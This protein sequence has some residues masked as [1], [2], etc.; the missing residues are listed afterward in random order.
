M[1]QIFLLVLFTCQLIIPQKLF[2]QTIN[3]IHYNL[4][5]VPDLSNRL[6]RNTGLPDVDIV[7]A[8]LKNIYPKIANYRRAM[9]QKDQYRV[10]LSSK[11]L[12]TIYHADFSRMYICLNAFAD[13]RK[14]IEYLKNRSKEANLSGATA[15]FMTEFTR[16]ETEA[17]KKTDGADL[18]SFFYSGVDA[19]LSSQYRNIIVLFTDGYIEAGISGARGCEEKQ[20]RYL[21]QQL[22]KQFRK[23]YQKRGDKN[24]SLEMFFARNRYGIIPV[25]N[26][27]LKSFD[28][29]LMQ[30]DDRSLSPTGNATVFPTDYDIMQLFWSDWMKKSGVQHFEMHPIARDT[31][32]AEQIILSFMGVK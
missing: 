29:L 12:G 26:P 2:A 17:R 25:D 21:S 4:V 1:K 13:Q 32:E 7:R 10:V 20:C 18:W 15:M 22:I 14:R 19:N 31:H 5:I 11:R 16:I 28:V 3:T 23:A 24:E 6:S 30:A 27:Y 9:Y 8:I